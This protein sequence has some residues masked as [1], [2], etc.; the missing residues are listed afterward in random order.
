[1][2]PPNRGAIA[3]SARTRL[4]DDL[5]NESSR[6]DPKLSAI[7]AGAKLERELEVAL[8]GE[9]G[10]DPMG[11]TPPQQSGDADAEL[12]ASVRGRLCVLDHL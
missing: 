5:H 2:A 3:G 7:V 9:G 12:F 11:D 4:L 10:I 1:M 8:T 6:V